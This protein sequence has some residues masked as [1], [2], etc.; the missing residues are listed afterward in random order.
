MTA[1]VHD[2]KDLYSNFTAGSTQNEN[3]Q[4]KKSTQ[5]QLSYNDIKKKNIYIYLHQNLGDRMQPCAVYFRK[6]GRTRFPCYFGRGLRGQL[7][8]KRTKLR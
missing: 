7:P 2:L 4:N 5:S 3:S 6:R 8:V 1:E